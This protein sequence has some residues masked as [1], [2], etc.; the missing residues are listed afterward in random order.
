MARHNGGARNAEAG[1]RRKISLALQGGGAHGAFTWGVLDRLLEDGRFEISGVTGAS[2]GA[3]NAV[4]LAE[5]MRRGGEQGA[6]DLLCEFWEGVCERARLSPVRRSPL[7]IWLGNWSVDH[8]P[9]LMMMDVLS[10]LVSPYEFNPLDINPLRSLV[11]RV[12]DFPALAS[13]GRISLFVSATDVESGGVRI[14][15]NEEI[16]LDAVLASAC[17]PYLFKAV[18]IDGRHY[19]DGGYVGNPSLTPCL[20]QTEADDVVLIQI[21]PA[22][23][24]GAPRTAR[25][26]GNRIDEITFNAS[27]VR[28][29]RAIAFIN[30]L[31]ANGARLPSRL[32]PLRLHRIAADEQLSA[33]SASS[34][35]NAEI[36]FVRHLHALGREAGAG[37]L[38]STGELVG[39][40][41]THDAIGG[42]PFPGHSAPERQAASRRTRH[43]PDRGH[44]GSA[45]AFRA[46][47]ERVCDCTSALRALFPTL[48][49]GA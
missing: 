45:Q 40:R 46:S 42:G 29:L 8:S 49:R 23:R 17:L 37:W 6:R 39:L 44:G 30:E 12:V 43:A 4:V 32:R 7:D 10:R 15:A 19:W 27:L 3:L 33:V 18:E 22:H 41:S 5:G 2:A 26:I 31:C 20:Y 24:R 47:V 34:K 48:K 35:L 13:E 21:N 11:R 38:A 9:G 1:S 28:E 36:G 16:T 25:G 14:F